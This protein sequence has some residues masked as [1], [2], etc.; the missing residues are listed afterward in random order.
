MTLPNGFPII[1]ITNQ[2]TQAWIEENLGTET[3]LI[4]EPQDHRDPLG[5]EEK[6]PETTLDDSLLPETFSELLTYTHGDNIADDI[7]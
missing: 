2:H 7:D 3:V 4:P 1:P 5:I 6:I